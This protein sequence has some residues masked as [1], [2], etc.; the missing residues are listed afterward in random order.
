MGSL[1]FFRDPN[2]SCKGSG[3][4]APESGTYHKGTRSTPTPYIE[5]T[6]TPLPYDLLTNA[7]TKLGSASGL[8]VTITT[9]P[10]NI[11]VAS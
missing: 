7:A 8:K 4:S 10:E 9:D 5:P 1:F 11:A 3:K 6:A 2:E